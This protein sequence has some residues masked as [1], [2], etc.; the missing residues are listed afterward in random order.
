MEDMLVEL[1]GKLRLTIDKFKNAPY[2]TGTAYKHELS[3]SKPKK[4]SEEKRKGFSNTSTT[5]LS[6]RSLFSRSYSIASSDSSVVWERILKRSN[7][8]DLFG[9][10]EQFKEMIK[11]IQELKAVNYKTAGLIVKEEKEED[12]GFFCDGNA[13]AKESQIKKNKDTFK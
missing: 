4:Q 8:P 10:K 12:F 5:S 6:G 3:L 13:M 9:S 1:R 2:M 11:D 7:K